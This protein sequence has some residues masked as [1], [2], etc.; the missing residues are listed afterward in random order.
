MKENILAEMKELPFYT[1]ISV[2]PARYKMKL[3]INNELVLN[4][5]SLIEW[6]HSGCKPLKILQIKG[7]YNK[8][9]VTSCEKYTVE[10]DGIITLITLG[11]PLKQGE[12][13][14]ISIDFTTAMVTSPLCDG[15]GSVL[16]PEGEDGIW[17]PYLAWDVQVG[18]HFAVE[19]TELED[20]RICMTGEKIGNVYTQDYM[21][22][23]GLLLCK[24]LEYAE[25]EVANVT[26]KAFYKKGDEKAAKDLIATSADAI[27]YFKELIGFYPQNSYSFLPYSSKWGGG[28]NWSTGIA[29]FHSMHK[30]NDMDGNEKPWIVPHEIGHHYWGEYVIDGD[31]CDWLW[32]GLGMVM[33]EE[34]SINRAINDANQSRTKSVVKYHQ[35]GNDT[36]IWRSIEEL[37]KVDNDYNMIIRHDKSFSIMQMLKQIIGKELLFDIMKYI[38][39]AYAGRELRTMDFWRICEEKS[40][41]Q[42]DWF[43]NDCLYSN[44]IATYE[45][46]PIEKDGSNTSVIINSFADFKFPVTT[47]IRFSDGSVAYKKLNRLMDAQVF[48]FDTNSTIDEINLNPNGDTLLQIGKTDNR[49]LIE[50]EKAGYEDD[51]KSL[52]RYNALYS[53]SIEDLD[54][55][56]KLASQLFTGKHYNESEIVLKM[57]YECESHIWHMISCI[58]LG[59][60]MDIIGKREQAISYYKE[61]LDIF[62]DEKF[63]FSQINLDVDRNWLNERLAT[64]YTLES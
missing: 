53:S 41:M 12:S 61:L 30:F 5:T 40:G 54:I 37:Q 24:G 47:E 1:P 48:R 46:T 51:G 10:Q 52:E 64:P 32:I 23:C 13:V 38:L 58:W 62:P 25:Q 27:Q 6:T 26:I 45:V 60:I 36:T 31:Y 7:C 9:M 44:R 35:K 33:D 34:Y 2:N 28:G 39:N 3:I 42:L 11:N 17:Y 8:L 19:V 16:M 29:F 49:L 4:G 63:N 57:L 21:R 59:L 15:D 56:F 18:G 55:L 20:Y 14:S 43:F 50:I 22:F